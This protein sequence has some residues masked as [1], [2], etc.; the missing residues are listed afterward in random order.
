M[1]Q[2]STNWNMKAHP[3]EGSGAVGKALLAGLQE[4]FAPILRMGN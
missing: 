3:D 1:S 4:V 2:I